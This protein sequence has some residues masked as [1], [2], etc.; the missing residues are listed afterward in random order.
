MP[1]WGEREEILS[2]ALS[3]RHA[4]ALLR[5]RDEESR[6]AAMHTV[7]RREMNVAATEEYID[8]LIEAQKEQRAVEKERKRANIV[9][10]SKS[11]LNQSEI[12]LKETLYIALK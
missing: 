12:F 5:L 3:E 2:A 8:R 1:V 9:E 6:R 10:K 4:R 7:I 11:L